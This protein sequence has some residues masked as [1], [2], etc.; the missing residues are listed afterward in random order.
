[1]MDGTFIDVVINKLQWLLDHPEVT[2]SGSGKQNI[3]IFARRT[4]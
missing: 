1:M 3:F 2:W 4:D